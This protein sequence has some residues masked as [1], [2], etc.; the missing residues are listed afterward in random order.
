MCYPYP[1]VSY[2]TNV[3]AADN[4]LLFV[5]IVIC[6]ELKHTVIINIHI[7]VADQLICSLLDNAIPKA[8]RQPEYLAM[9][10]ARMVVYA[11]KVVHSLP[12]FFGR[13]VAD[14]NDMDY[15]CKLILICLT[16]STV[17]G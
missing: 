14:I 6:C 16:M 9:L 15:F 13:L 3:I 2:V 12:N 4:I 17:L 11:P 8:S 5:T 10:L 1:S 7:V